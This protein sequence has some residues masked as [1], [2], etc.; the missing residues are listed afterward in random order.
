MLSL[1]TI[2][3]IARSVKVWIIVERRCPR[4]RSVDLTDLAVSRNSCKRSSQERFVFRST[5][6]RVWDLQVTSEFSVRG[7]TPSL[8]QQ[9]FLLPVLRA[10]KEIFVSSHVR[11]D[12]YLVLVANHRTVE[13]DDQLDALFLELV[14]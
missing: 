1:R 11:F 10:I 13:A 8:K 4:I 7:H 12:T 14:S 3:R 9:L 2:A 5:S 6:E